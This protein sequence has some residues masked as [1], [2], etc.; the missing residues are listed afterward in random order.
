MAA[1]LRSSSRSRDGSTSS[2]ACS[3]PTALRPRRG[4]AARVH[5]SSS[6]FDM[7]APADPGPSRPRSTAARPRG[8]DRHPRG[9]RGTRSGAPPRSCGPRS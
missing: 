1:R 5:P 6:Q 3:R 7:Q 9:R 8:D 4:D 2:S